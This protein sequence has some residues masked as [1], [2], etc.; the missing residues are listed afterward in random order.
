MVVF[1]VLEFLW[2]QCI[3]SL[4]VI[5]ENGKM[6]IRPY[7]HGMLWVIV[8]YSGRVDVFVIQCRIMSSSPPPSPRCEASYEFN[9]VVLVCYVCMRLLWVE[10]YFVFDTCIFRRLARCRKIL[11]QCSYVCY[12]CVW[13]FSF[14]PTYQYVY[15]GTLLCLKLT[16]CIVNFKRRAIQILANVIN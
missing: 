15:M 13:K 1:L 9:S 8:T 14:S 10:M 2:V 12:V 5:A 7:R 11:T 3:C 16:A 6:L 4:R